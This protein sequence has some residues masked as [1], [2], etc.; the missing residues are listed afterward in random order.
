M[1]S[2]IRY[3][4]I[5]P[6][7]P[8]SLSPTIA[9][10]LLRQELGYDG[11]VLSDDLDMGAVAKHYTLPVIIEQCMTAEV[12][13]MLICHAGPKIDQAF[14]LLVERL[15]HDAPSALAGMGSVRR[16]LSV[17]QKLRV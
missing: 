9:R 15:T 3:P 5:D 13:L 6:R 1:L 14:E 11:L 16:I 7:W 10:D 2:H 17:K 4:E 12:D 8:A